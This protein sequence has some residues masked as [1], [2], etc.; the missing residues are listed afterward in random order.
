MTWEERITAAPEVLGGKPVIRGTRVAVEFVLDLLG[1]GW[2][3]QDVV[4][5]YP[6]IHAEDVR[7][8]LLYA[9]AV[10]SEERVLPLAG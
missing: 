6:G 1:G 2:S 9:R 8:C 4:D 3:E 10:L 7:A 5:N